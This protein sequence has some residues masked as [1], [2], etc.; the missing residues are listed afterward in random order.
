[1]TERLPIEVVFCG[2]PFDRAAAIH[3]LRHLAMR[4]GWTLSPKAV[5]R[6]LYVTD[7]GE[8]T[9][10]RMTTKGYRCALVAACQAASANQY[11]TYSLGTR[12]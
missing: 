9:R 1:M 12:Q 10:V 4:V 6:L 2:A 11:P 8:L 3:T 7:R 5:H